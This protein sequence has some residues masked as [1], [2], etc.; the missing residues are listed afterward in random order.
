MNTSSNKQRKQYLDYTWPCRLLSSGVYYLTG[1]LA[2]LKR[3]IRLHCVPCNKTVE[4]AVGQGC[5][6]RS[7]RAKMR[8]D[9]KSLVNLF[10]CDL[11]FNI[12]PDYRGM[13]GACMHERIMGIVVIGQSSK[14]G[15]SVSREVF[16]CVLCSLYSFNYVV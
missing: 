7:V 3:Q 2:G 10:F 9:M 15:Q 6:A 5:A 11:H 12:S 4:T 8:R 16:T 1:R 13:H 14:V